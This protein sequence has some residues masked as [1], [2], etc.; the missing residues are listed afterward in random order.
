LKDDLSER[1]EKRF[2]EVFTFN[3]EWKAI[4]LQGQPTRSEKIF[5]LPFHR[6]GES[7]YEQLG[8]TSAFQGREPDPQH[9]EALCRMIRDVGME[10]SVGSQ[11]RSSGNIQEPVMKKPWQIDPCAVPPEGAEWLA[12]APIFRHERRS[13]MKGSNYFSTSPYSALAPS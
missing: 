3:C 6:W 7:K 13:L 10:A 2:H 8:V 11:G 12:H 5:R 1:S 9:V 4:E